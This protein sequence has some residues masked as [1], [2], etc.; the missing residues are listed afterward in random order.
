MGRA[1]AL[2]LL[3]G[4][5]AA[6][7]DVRGARKF[8]DDALDIARE[9]ENLL[10]EAEIL[11]GRAELHAEVGQVALAHA[12]LQLAAATYRRLGAVKRLEQVETTL[13]NL[14]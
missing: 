1:D 5:A 13:A 3:G 9:H 2:R 14:S 10:L 7:S 12:D 6:Q 11:E 4:V 8:F